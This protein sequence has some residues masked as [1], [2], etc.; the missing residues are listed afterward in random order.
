MHRYGNSDFLRVTTL[1]E[2][3]RGNLFLGGVLSSQRLLQGVS[4]RVLQDSAGLR[5]IL[6]GFPNS[7]PTGR[8]VT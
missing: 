8:L 5:G 7:D 6:R 1:T 2:A 3:L 4:S